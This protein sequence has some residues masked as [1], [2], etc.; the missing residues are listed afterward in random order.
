MRSGYLSEYVSF[1]KEFKGIY[2]IFDTAYI[3]KEDA[4][5]YD[6]SK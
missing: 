5:L 3:T 1:K 6:H 2:V 4:C